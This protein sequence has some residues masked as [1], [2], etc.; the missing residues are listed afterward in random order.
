MDRGLAGGLWLTREVL[1]CDGLSLSCVWIFGSLERRVCDVFH[2]E[3]GFRVCRLN[4]TVFRAGSPLRP[5]SP[6]PPLQQVPPHSA[7]VLPQAGPAPNPSSGQSAYAQAAFQQPGGGSFSQPPPYGHGS[8]PP[9]QLPPYGQGTAPPPQ[10]QPPV[11]LPPQ[12]SSSVA[13]EPGRSYVGVTRPPVPGQVTFSGAPGGPLAAQQFQ[14]HLYGAPP[15]GVP[16]ASF[17]SPQGPPPPTGSAF[18]SYRPPGPPA[19]YNPPGAAS[20][21]VPMGAPPSISA[22]SAAPSVS[23][24]GKLAGPPPGQPSFG[25]PGAAQSLFGPP[26]APSQ[27]LGQD[28]RPTTGPPPLGSRYAATPPPGPSMQY[29]ATTHSQPPHFVATPATY[30]R[31]QTAG[32]GPP[33]QISAGHGGGAID[34]P[35]TLGSYPATQETAMQ[36]LSEDF[37]SLPVVPAPGAMDAAIDPAMLPRPSDQTEPTFITFAANCHPRFMRLTTNA[38]PNSHSLLARWHLPLGTI[39]H[40][41]AEPPKGVSVLLF[42]LSLTRSCSVRY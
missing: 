17:L 24:G 29:G 34:G 22:T 10:L 6:A 7:P 33:S 16:P 31:N 37:Q 35:P 8:A 21:P 13:A 14:K 11:Q 9:P 12:G 23:G 41:F 20:S 30:G 36:P 27:G 42:V 32:Y 4:F 26:V 38:M 3:A 28:L 15:S 1:V 5:P 39:V 19:S 2:N 18:P 25:H 40:P